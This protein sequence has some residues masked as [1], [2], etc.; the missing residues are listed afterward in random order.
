MFSILN[1]KNSGRYLPP[2]LAG[3]CFLTACTDFWSE[4]NKRKFLEVCTE[5]AADWATEHE[6]DEYCHCVLGK[7]MQRYPNE[8]D[9]FAHIEE[10]AKDTELI[11]CRQEVAEKQ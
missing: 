11:N 3:I 9:A 10:L 2:I 7:M 8:L 1:V 5:E 4:A 6:A